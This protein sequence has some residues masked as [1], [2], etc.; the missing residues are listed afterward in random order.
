[1]YTQLSAPSIS[2]SMI[3]DEH[4]GKKIQVHQSKA[5]PG[6]TGQQGHYGELSAVTRHVLQAAS[7]NMKTNRRLVD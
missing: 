2:S 3:S 1:M 6:A 7:L 5:A 4:I